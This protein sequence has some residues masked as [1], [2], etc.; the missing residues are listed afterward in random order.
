MSGA[1]AGRW[2]SARAARDEPGT[3]T[4][5]VVDGHRNGRRR[6]A[7]APESGRVDVRRVAKQPGS[8]R[9]HAPPGHERMEAEIECRRRP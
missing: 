5:A 9:W 4:A 3:S 2:I 6:A 1:Q 7:R 8:V